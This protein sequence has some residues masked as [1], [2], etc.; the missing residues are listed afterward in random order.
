MNLPAIAI[1]SAAILTLLSLVMIAVIIGLRL[2]TDRRIHH[3]AEFR[4]KGLLILKA[5]LADEVSIE[6][7]STVLHQNPKVALLLLMEI[8]EKLEP[9]ARKK[10]H[11]L[12]A[13][14]PFEKKA[15]AELTGK[16]WQ[17]RLH[18]AEQLGYIAEDPALPQLMMTL[19]DSVIS[20]RYAA[21]KSLVRLGCRDAVVP[22]ILALDL[23]NDISQRSIAEILMDLGESSVEPIL[24][25]LKNPSNTH[26]MLSI[27][28]RV[29]GMLKNGRN[30]PYLQQ[31]LRHEHPDV[32][33]NAVRALASIGNRSS[34]VPISTL[35]EDSSWEVRSSVMHALGKLLAADQIPV[36]LQGLSDQEWWVR[37]NAAQAL[38]S[39]GAQ[40][41]KTLKDAVT[42]HVD[43]YGRAMSARILQE[44]GI[45][46]FTTESHT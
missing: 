5:F 11:C 4:K 3:D 35:C 20:V 33:L 19:R 10:L 30:L 9:P 17:K 16:R 1:I 32:R 24:G 15:V 14:L 18:A 39:L 7:A 42:Y 22:I 43:G 13:M 44:H 41:L 6:V 2:F 40:G 31:L 28:A 37:Y 21:A 38:Y 46:V 36:L 27:A 25:I 23:P 8:S 12:S 34:I 26:S 29:A 45:P